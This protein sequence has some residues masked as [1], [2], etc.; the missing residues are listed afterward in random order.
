MWRKPIS[1]KSWTRVALSN[2]MTSFICRETSTVLRTKVPCSET[3]FFFSFSIPSGTLNQIFRCFDVGKQMVE[4][5][6]WLFL[7]LFLSQTTAWPWAPGY[8]FV[9]FVSPETAE[10]SLRLKVEAIFLRNTWH[11]YWTW[12][13]VVHGLT[14]ADG[15]PIQ[16]WWFSPCLITRWSHFGNRPTIFSEVPRVYDAHYGGHKC[17]DPRLRSQLEEPRLFSFARVSCWDLICSFDFW[18]LSWNRLN[19]RFLQICNLWSFVMICD[20]YL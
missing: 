11:G 3:F 16:N 1:C 7:D 15:F 13:K 19:L 8:A 10:M 4:M 20:N 12:L 18:N 5:C 6:F 2:S 17:C 9:N 14:I